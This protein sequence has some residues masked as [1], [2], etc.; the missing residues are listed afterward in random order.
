MTHIFIYTYTYIYIYIYIY[1][2]VYI[3]VYICTCIHIYVHVYIY[4]YIYVHMHIYMYIYICTSDAFAF[5]CDC[6]DERMRELTHQWTRSAAVRP[7]MV[8][9]KRVPF[10]FFCL[11]SC[12]QVFQQTS[13][14]ALHD[15]LCPTSRNPHERTK[16]HT[17]G[18]HRHFDYCGVP[19]FHLPSPTERDSCYL[20]NTAW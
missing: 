15:K 6:V 10:V 18:Q 8:V 4:V 20:C 12:V 2:Y 17:H 9:L 19:L 7:R 13:R 16:A 14:L 11:V 5:T 1:T 3:N